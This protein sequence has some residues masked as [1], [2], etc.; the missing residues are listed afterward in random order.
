LKDT[1]GMSYS[2]ADIAVQAGYYCGP[3]IAPLNWVDV[4]LSFIDD[5]Y[6]IRGKVN[7]VNSTVIPDCISDIYL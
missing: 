4:S 3:P 1:Q 5:Q 7:L 2:I 6:R